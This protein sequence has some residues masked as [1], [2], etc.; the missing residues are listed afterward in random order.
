V[1]NQQTNDH[2]QQPEQKQ[3]RFRRTRKAA[4]ILRSALFFCTSKQVRTRITNIAYPSIGR[5]I[6][7]SHSTQTSYRSTVKVE[8]EW[9]RPE[10]GRRNVMI[11]SSTMKATPRQPY[12]RFYQRQ[13]LYHD[14][15]IKKTKM[16]KKKQPGVSSRR[17]EEA[18]LSHISQ[19]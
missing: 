6:L 18:D 14:D 17:P 16:T 15:K 19:N 8:R 7:A 4:I 13:R 3:E 11:A 10:F 1:T 9:D 5:S 2:N 12:Q